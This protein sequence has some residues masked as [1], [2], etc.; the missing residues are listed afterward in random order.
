MQFRFLSGL[1]ITTHHAYRSHGYR[2]LLL[3]HL[4]ACLIFR[5]ISHKPMHLGSASFTQECSTMSPK[6]PLIVGSKGQTSTSR[7]T[8]TLPAWVFALL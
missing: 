3:F 6:N 1:T 7:V 5:T 8:E 2:I 4:F